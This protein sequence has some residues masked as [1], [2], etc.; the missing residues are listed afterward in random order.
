MGKGG[1]GGAA[2]AGTGEVARPV[3]PYRGDETHRSHPSHRAGR[4]RMRGRRR[5]PG[6]CRLCT[7]WNAAS[8]L[9]RVSVGR[10]IGYRTDMP[11]IVAELLCGCCFLCHGSWPGSF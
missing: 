6:S 7:G 8:R 3:G 5:G 4:R 10:K 11:P 1:D 2:A 9:W